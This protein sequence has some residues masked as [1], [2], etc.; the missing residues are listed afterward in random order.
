M[1]AFNV[2]SVGYGAGS[3]DIAGRP[4]VVQVVIG[5]TTASSPVPEPGQLVRLLETNID[6][7]TGEV[8]YAEDDT[9][10]YDLLS[11]IVIRTLQAGGEAIAVRADEVSAEI[12]N[13]GPA[14]A[15][16]RFALAV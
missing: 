2:A 3:A 9:H 15:H 12:W 5:E 11:R 7:A 10:G 16:L 14:L 4:N 13:G 1:P 6:D 8:S